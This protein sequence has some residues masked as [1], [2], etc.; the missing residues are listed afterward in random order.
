[1]SLKAWALRHRWAVVVI[2]AVPI[3]L[4]AIRFTLV[5]TY[6]FALDAHERR[7][8]ATALPIVYGNA[9]FLDPAACSL[10]GVMYLFGQG[11]QRDGSKAEYWLTKAAEANVVEAQ[12]LLGIMY[13]TGQGIPRN[14]DF[15]R[16]WLS[17]AAEAGD[18]EA[19]RVLRALPTAGKV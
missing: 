2:C 3:A 9:L 17:R 7:D 10:L 1:M 6:G 19:R 13:A 11:V 18:V 15:A 4:T 5:R 12:S 14:I 8:Y 16:M